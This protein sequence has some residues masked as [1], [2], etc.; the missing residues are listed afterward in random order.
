MSISHRKSRQAPK[1]SSFL[2][3]PIRSHG[4][5]VATTYRT[6]NRFFSI[7][8]LLQ[9]SSQG[10]SVREVYSRLQDEHPADER[11]YR[12]DLENLEYL[13]FLTTL[14][15]EDRSGAH[16][17]R[18]RALRTLD[19]GRTLK[20][21]L[22]E[23]FA[24]YLAK[25]V[26]LPLRDTPFYDDLMGVFSKIEAI[27]GPKAQ[28]HLRGLTSEVHFEPGPRW[29]LG[30]DPLTLDVVERCC[31][32]GHV[33]EVEYTPGH[34]GAA[35]VRRLGPH[36]LYFSKGSL[37]LVAEDFGDQVVKVF[38][39]PRMSKAV[40]SEEPYKTDRINPEEF[41]AASFGVYRGSEVEHVVL[42]FKPPHAAH[43]R[44][45]RWHESQR[46]TPRPDGTLEVSLDVAST[47]DLVHW[48]LGFGTAVEV[49][50]P[51][52]L[53][54]AVSGVAQEVVQIYQSGVSRKRQRLPKTS[55]RPRRKKSAG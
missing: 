25:N 40:M 55:R 7:L 54:R 33:L 9:R 8:N 52:G 27:L 6:L 30:L 34:G 35:G 51:P 18:F 2:E 47:P 37:Y 1:Y 5:N 53:V 46:V 29:G 12:R 48:I 28:E 50:S 31:A 11:T 16:V 13:G 19:V 49:V 39:L 36:F 21:E 23:L 17:T 22:R 38:A 43:V 41:F 14:R 45:R 4:T 24:L 26:L 42:I 44:E 3:Y 32:E 15:E 20:L 10:L